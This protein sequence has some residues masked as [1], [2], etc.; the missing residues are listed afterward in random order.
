MLQKRQSFV[1]LFKAMIGYISQIIQIQPA[2]HYKWIG[3]FMPTLA[4]LIYKSS[5]S[6][7]GTHKICFATKSWKNY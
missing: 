6:S 2:R 4:M 7:T 3:D 5:V 1:T